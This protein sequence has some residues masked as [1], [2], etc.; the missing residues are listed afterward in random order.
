MFDSL[1]LDQQQRWRRGERVLVETIL[2]QNPYLAD[3]RPALVDLIYGE[4]VLREA[5]GEAPTL[6]EYVQRFPQ[7][8][9][10]LRRQFAVHVAVPGAVS[11]ETV[12]PGDRPP[13][14]VRSIDT[15]VQASTPAANPPA[16]RTSSREVTSPLT[17][18]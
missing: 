11:Q 13:P 9:T 15:V 18:A 10:E 4:V 6:E 2:K 1:R 17:K 14:S 3:D 12:V 5:Q 8:E 7:C 16:P